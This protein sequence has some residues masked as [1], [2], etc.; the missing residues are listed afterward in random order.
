MICAGPSIA[1]PSNRVRVVCGLGVTMASLRPTNRLSSVDLPAFGAPISATWPHRAGGA[2]AS[3]TVSGCVLLCPVDNL[4]MS[5]E[6]HP[7]ARLRVADDFFEDPNPR[8]IADNV[9]MHSELKDAAFVVSGIEFALEYIEHVGRWR[10]GSQC[11][12][13]I[14]HEINRVITHPLDRQFDD[15]GRLAIE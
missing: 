15:P 14:H 4:G 7:L 13:P 2:W 5:S 9:R 12:E 10:I 8:P 6:P 1:I 3:S 11:R